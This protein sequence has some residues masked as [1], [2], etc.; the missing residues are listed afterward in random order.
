MMSYT[1]VKTESASIIALFF[2]AISII[3]K[4]FNYLK[5]KFFLFFTLFYFFI[6]FNSFYSEY[7][8]LSF[9]SSLF[10][11]RF[12]FFAFGMAYFLEHYNKFLKYFFY[13]LL[14]TFIIVSL[15]A[16]Y[17]WLTGYNFLGWRLTTLDR[18]SGLFGDEL[19]L[20]SFF[21]RLLPLF[22]GLYFF[23]NKKI[24]N[25][26]SFVYL[27]ILILVLTVLIFRSGERISLIY[28]AIFFFFYFMIFSQ[29]FFK[30]LIT[31]ISI[32]I[33]TFITMAIYSE[34]VKDKIKTSIEHITEERVYFKYFPATKHHESHYLTALEIFNDNKI[35]GSGVNTFRK[36]CDNERYTVYYDNYNNNSCST[37]PHHSYIQLL[38]E[39]GIIGVSFIIILLIYISYEIA[40]TSY[41]LFVKKDLNYNN[42]KEYSKLFI[43]ICFLISLWPLGPSGNF[44]NNWLNIMYYLPL[45]FYFWINS[46]KNNI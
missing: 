37:H 23:L 16:Y 43:L 39:T 11:F 3:K 18:L 35:M 1:L 2:V 38:S 21:S 14:L 26:K 32:L 30:T 33:L 17:Q 36:L 5:S 25:Y 29:I 19:I 34:G 40:K 10:Y 8:F 6:I 12:I 13:S 44:F 22:C 15:D 45:G 24:N 7:S 27:T 46:K 4:E 9:E 42:R 41:Y 31:S 28:S 20:G